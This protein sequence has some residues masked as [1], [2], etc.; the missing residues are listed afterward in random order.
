MDKNTKKI[1]LNG[2][3]ISLVC[4]AT[5]AI[6]IPVPGTNGYVNIGDAIIFITSIL[7]GPTPG[8]IAG[9]IGSALA[10][11]LSGYAHWA[12]FTLIVKGIEGYL[13]GLIVNKFKAT[14][15]GIVLA[16]LLGSVVMV[17]GYFIFGAYLSGGFAASL[18]SVPSNCIQGV[19]SMILA[20]PLVYS[21]R[22]IKYINSLNIKR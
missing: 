11:I 1:V 8:M 19:I 9:G 6:Q 18:I 22:D 14:N 10:D 13:V 16:T 4:L 17:F 3:M 20:I 15:L 7:F 2:L 5:M 12:L 21:L